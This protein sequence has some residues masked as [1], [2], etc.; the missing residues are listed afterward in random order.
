MRFWVECTM[1]TW[2]L[3]LGR[4]EAYGA[5]NVSLRDRLA[6]VW[7]S[8]ERF[9]GWLP[10][11]SKP[12]FLRQLPLAGICCICYGKSACHLHPCAHG[13]TASRAAWHLCVVAVYAHQN[14][15]RTLWL[16]AQLAVVDDLWLLTWHSTSCP[17]VLR[18]LQGKCVRRLQAQ[19][20]M[21]TNIL[22]CSA[23]GC[24]S[25]AA[26]CTVCS[27]WH[28]SR[29]FSQRKNR[30]AAHR[31]IFRRGSTHDTRRLLDRL[32]R[33]RRPLLG[34]LLGL[35]LECLEVLPAHDRLRLCRMDI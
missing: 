34:L 3:C 32:R 30:S 15:L 2:H 28:G 6:P 11:N 12:R 16:W 31:D 5:R 8:C 29:A 18:R 22:Y 24:V 19:I 35:R 23:T 20:Q 26:G 25:A 13:V 9:W 1:Q 7:L 27:C 14:K 10:C 33:R 21:S 4:F 17:L